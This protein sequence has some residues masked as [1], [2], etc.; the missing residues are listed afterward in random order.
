MAQNA[1]HYA[2]LDEVI[3]AGT[4]V[5]NPGDPEDKAATTLRPAPTVPARGFTKPI[6]LDSNGN[7]A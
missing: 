3:A 4:A 1:I 6:Y 5:G 7:P 2:E